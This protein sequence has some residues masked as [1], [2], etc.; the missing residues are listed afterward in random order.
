MSDPIIKMICDAHGPAI[1][2]F[3]QR[4]LGLPEGGPFELVQPNLPPGTIEADR[5]FRLELPE[6]MLLHTEWES[7]SKLGRAQ[8]FLEYNVLLTRQSALPVQTVVVL[9]RKEANSSDMTGEHSLRTPDGCE[10]LRFGYR[11]IRLWELPWEWMLNDPGLTPFAGLCA[12]QEADLPEVA[13]RLVDTWAGLDRKEV[14]ELLTATKVL[15]SWRWTEVDIEDMFR[16]LKMIAEESPYVKKIE[17]RG[18]AEGIA[19]GARRSLVRI[20]GRKFGPMSEEVQLA[21]DQITD[22]D[23]LERMCEAILT[24][25]DWEMVL[26]VK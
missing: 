26:A 9:I 13:R 15:M 10:Y 21:I 20:G 8:R 7:A 24:A 6:P 16:G 17:A 3:F 1:V 12:I 18:R 22:A 23:R 14:A 4:W 11:V 19:V 5:V 2:G 25:T